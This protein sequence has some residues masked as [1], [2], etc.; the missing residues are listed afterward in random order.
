MMIHNF[1]E[2][3]DNLTL[4]RQKEGVRKLFNLI[5]DDFESHEGLIE[6]ILIEARDVESNDGFGTEGANI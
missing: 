1:I 5:M 3:Y 2:E 6:N 4:P